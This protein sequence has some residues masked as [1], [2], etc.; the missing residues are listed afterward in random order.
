M[1]KPLVHIRMTRFY[2]SFGF[3]H[4]STSYPLVITRLALH[5]AAEQLREGLA[6][7]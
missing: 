1:Q 6:A 7:L 3:A 2:E 5:R 4:L